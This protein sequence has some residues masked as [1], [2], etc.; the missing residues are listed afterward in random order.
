MKIINKLFGSPPKFKKGDV[1][2]PTQEYLDYMNNNVLTRIEW[3]VTRNHR[4]SREDGFCVEINNC[5]NRDYIHEKWLKLKVRDTHNN[6]KH[7][8][9]MSQRLKLDSFLRYKG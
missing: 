3:K 6:T 8:N 5:R 1:V 9:W 2:E 4:I 7:S